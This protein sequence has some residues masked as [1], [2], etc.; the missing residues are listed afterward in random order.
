MAFISL[1]APRI[2]W[3]R[4]CSNT[5]NRYHIKNSYFD[6]SDLVKSEID[7]TEIDRTELDQT[8]YDQSYFDRSDFDQSEFV[9]TELYKNKYDQ[10]E[11]IGSGFDITL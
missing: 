2:I 1:G 8:E 7:K 10:T 4:S 11:H 5:K 9:E 6:L 3:S